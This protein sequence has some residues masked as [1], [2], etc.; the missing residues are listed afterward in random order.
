MEDYLLSIIPYT[1]SKSGG[2]DV[3]G[4]NYIALYRIIVDEEATPVAKRRARDKWPTQDPRFKA[5]VAVQSLPTKSIRAK[6]NANRRAAET[7]KKNKA[8]TANVSRKPTAT[9]KR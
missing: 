3:E 4:W 2:S 6:R 9:K 5:G 7:A 1:Q 8:I